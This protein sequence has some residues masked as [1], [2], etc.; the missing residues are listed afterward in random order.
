MIRI[1][2]A[3]RKQ[4]SSV[5]Q[6]AKSINL[7]AQGFR[8]LSGRLDGLKEL[9]IKKYALMVAVGVMATYLLDTYREDELK[10]VAD[11]NTRLTAEQTKL[12]ADLAKTKGYEDIKK[13][14]DEDEKILRT[15]IDTIQQLLKDRQTPPKLLGA[16]P[17]AMPKDLWLTNFKLEADLATFKGSSTDFNQISDFMKG[18]GE[19]AFFTDVKLK[20]TQQGIDEGTNTPVVNFELTAGRRR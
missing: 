19:S 6:E 2:L 11:E 18:L 12:Q 14:L 15:K 3:T 1:N 5:V 4:G 8:D 10:K 20:L 7:N 16:L 13:G 17:G 9:P